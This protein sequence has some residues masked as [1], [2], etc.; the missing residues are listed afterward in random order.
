MTRRPVP[1]DPVTLTWWMSRRVITDALPEHRT[2]VEFAYRGEEPTTIWLVIER[3]QTSVCTDPP[4]FETDLVVS[5]EPVELMRVFAGITS[6]AR[7]AA[8]GT[9][10]VTGPKRLARELPHWFAWS[11]FAPAVRDRLA[12]PAS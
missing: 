4:G 7:A 5:T 2:V 6:Y 3:R 11:P 12:T 9:I 8:S 1:V 10:V